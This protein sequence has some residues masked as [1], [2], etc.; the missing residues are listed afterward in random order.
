MQEGAAPHCS[1][2]KGSSGQHTTAIKEEALVTDLFIQLILI[3]CP[4]WGIYLRPTCVSVNNRLNM[5]IPSLPKLTSSD[6]LSLT[7]D[8]DTS[9][10]CG[11]DK[12][13]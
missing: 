9:S 12:L 10:L 11:L 2:G 5:K 13:F 3:E 6:N 8:S 4:L 7:P 1:G